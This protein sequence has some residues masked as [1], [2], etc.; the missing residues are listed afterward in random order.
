MRLRLTHMVAIA[1]L[2]YLPGLLA[3][4]VAQLL[5]LGLAGQLVAVVAVEAPIITAAALRLARAR[6]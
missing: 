4:I 6:R 5:G 3:M 2:A 1:V